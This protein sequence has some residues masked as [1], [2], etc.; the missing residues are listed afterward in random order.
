MRLST[1]GATHRTM[2]QNQVVLRHQVIYFPMSLGVCVLASK[3]TSER[4]GKAR[5]ELVVQ[6][7]QYLRPDSWLF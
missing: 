7:A 1:P 6:V 4:T 2:G 5:N 3:Q